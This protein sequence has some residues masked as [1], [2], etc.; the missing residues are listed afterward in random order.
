MTLQTDPQLKLRMPADLKMAI[1]EAAHLSNRSVTAEIVHRL[2]ISVSSTIPARPDNGAP[3]LL[4][5]HG[6]YWLPDG[7]GF[8]GLKAAAGRYT[9]EEADAYAG[10]TIVRMAYADAPEVVPGASDEIR[11]KYWEQQTLKLRHLLRL[12][13][14][15]EP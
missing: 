14:A 10:R 3:W 5:S 2:Q 1:E 13:I 8:T 12:A 9:A 6:F 15:L 7:M 11:A 4:I